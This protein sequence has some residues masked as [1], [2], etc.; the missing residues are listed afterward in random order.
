MRPSFRKF[1]DGEFVY[2]DDV[3]LSEFFK[4]TSEADIST[5]ATDRNGRVIY[6]NDII[7][8][9]RLVSFE[10]KKVEYENVAGLV[11]W[12]DG[13]S[14]MWMHGMWMDYLEIDEDAVV[15]GNIYENEEI[16]DQIK[17]EYERPP[18]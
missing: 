8:M 7:A 3:G 12:D 6:E 13:P 16:A 14:M 9:D 17:E 4:D 15:I 5:G 2:S 1:K 11:V 10:K 18:F